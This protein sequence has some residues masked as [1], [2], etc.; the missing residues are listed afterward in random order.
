MFI[1]S[2]G[3]MNRLLTEKR[4][5]FGGMRMSLVSKKMNHH[6]AMEILKWNYE[7]PYDFYNNEINDES[8][9]ELLEENYMAI[10]DLKES[11]TGFYCSGESAQVPAGREAGAYNEAA[12]DVGIGMNPNLTGKGKGKAFFSFILTELQQA[13]PQSII[14]LTVAAFNERA[15]KLYSNMGFK[16]EKEFNSGVN[17]FITM[18]KR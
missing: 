7:P 8:I 11:L 9:R 10:I 14:R 5:S 18:V 13:L 12:I 17:R 15:I 2:I 3:G 4:L 6:Y 16:K 1:I